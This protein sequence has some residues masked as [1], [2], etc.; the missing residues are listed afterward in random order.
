MVRTEAATV[1]SDATVADFVGHHLLGVRLLEVPV[2]DGAAYLG[3]IGLADV[4]SMERS[5]WADTAVADVMRTDQPVVQL[6]GTVRQALAEMEA[7]DTERL[8]VLDGAAYVGM[9]TMG[10]ILKLGE[11]LGATEAAT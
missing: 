5:R 1:P 7:G 6:S 4:T 3:M 11:I 9:V 10:E 8:A 2:V